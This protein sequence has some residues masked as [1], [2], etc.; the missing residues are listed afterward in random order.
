MDKHEEHEHER[1]QEAALQLESDGFTFQVH[2]GLQT[3][4]EATGRTVLPADLVDDAVVPACAQ[5]TVL[6]WEESGRDI[7]VQ[8]GSPTPPPP[9]GPDTS[10]HC[11]HLHSKE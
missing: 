11:S 5:V 8:G 1:G 9:G 6:P 7:M 3:L 4:P 10:Y 2:A